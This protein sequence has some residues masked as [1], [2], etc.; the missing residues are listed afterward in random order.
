MSSEAAQKG[1]KPLQNHA[2]VTIAG[3]QQL[4]GKY[5]STRSVA[6]IRKLRIKGESELENSRVPSRLSQPHRLPLA[7]IDLLDFDYRRVILYLDLGGHRIDV[8]TPNE[9]DLRN[10]HR[11]IARFALW[12]KAEVAPARQAKVVALNENQISGRTIWIRTTVDK[13]DATVAFN[14]PDTPLRL[15]LSSAWIAEILHK[16]RRRILSQRRLP[17]NESH[18]AGQGHCYGTA[19]SGLPCPQ[20]FTSP[21]IST[22]LAR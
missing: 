20:G 14:E 4:A 21:H 13:S 12:A 11:Q 8:V 15:N 1:M 16:A 19:E 6:R 22:P 7:R 3:R 18:H 17:C 5:K 10:L 2:A 9:I